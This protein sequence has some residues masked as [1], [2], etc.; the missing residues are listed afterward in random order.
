[1]SRKA[2]VPCLLSLTLQANRV[3]EMDFVVGGESRRE[4]R[5]LCV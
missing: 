5:P 2:I 4:A 3:V 1:M